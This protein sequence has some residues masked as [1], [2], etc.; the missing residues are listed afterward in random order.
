MKINFEHEVQKIRAID[1][2]LEPEVLQSASKTVINIKD[3]PETFKVKKNKK[4][5]SV[6]ETLLKIHMEK[7]AKREQRH[8]EKMNLLRSLLEK[9]NNR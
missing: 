5:S 9:D 6:V 2:S 4:K 3:G 1:D 8:E 7:E